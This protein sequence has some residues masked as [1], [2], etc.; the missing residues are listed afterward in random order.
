MAR[1]G[2]RGGRDDQQED[3]AYDEPG[4][5][6]LALVPLLFG[7]C[8]IDQWPGL[9]KPAT[10]TPWDMFVAARLAFAVADNDEAIRLW[11]EIAS[12][13]GIDSRHTLQA[14]T[15]LRG[16]GVQPGPEQA[17]AVLGVV[18]C[19]PVQTGHD[20]LAAYR[21]GSVRYINFSGAAVI[22]DD[23]PAPVRLAAQQLLNRSSEIVGGIGPWTEPQLPPLPGGAARL[24]MLTPSGPHFG[25]GPYDALSADPI[26]RQFLNTA[27][28]LMKA[29]IGISQPP[30]RD[31]PANS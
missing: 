16:A 17:R 28:T 23:A 6:G 11:R 5:G 22:I 13:P 21:D 4:T 7:D 20:V 31:G 25:Q 29:V 3:P 26:A 2:R 18:A 24:M 27:F 14:W 12:L 1:F 30:R 9:G 8:P 19:V 10:D 15:F